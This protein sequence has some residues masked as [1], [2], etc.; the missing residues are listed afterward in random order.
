MN[1]LIPVAMPSSAAMPKIRSGNITRFSDLR[2]SGR[3]DLRGADR[4]SHAVEDRNALAAAQGRECFGGRAEA[5]VDVLPIVHHPDI[6]G[7]VDREIGLHLETA[8]TYPPGGEICSPVFMPGGQ[9]AVRTP[10]SCTIGLLAIAKFENQTLSLPSTT[11][12]QGPGRP[13]PVNGEPGYSLP[14]GRSSETL[15]PSGPPFCLNMVRVRISSKS[16]PL[17]MAFT[18]SSRAA[19]PR[20][21]LPNRLVTQ[22]LPWLSMASPLPL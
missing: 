15:P 5:T 6:A 8:P 4:L 17:F 1:T 21:E 2:L 10:Q 9:F 11:A 13:P 20:A 18:I 7:R 12:A 14:S 22:T 3:A 19:L 16:P